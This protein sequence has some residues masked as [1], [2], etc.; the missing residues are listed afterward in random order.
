MMPKSL[1]AEV[2]EASLG[3]T[4]PFSL[5][6]HM[7]HYL[8]PS[9]KEAMPNEVLKGFGKFQQPFQSRQLRLPGRRDN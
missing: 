3:H 4:S 8:V 1:R 5:S 2:L 9:E 7:V 6:L